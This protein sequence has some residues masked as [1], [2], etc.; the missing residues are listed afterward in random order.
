LH[1]ALAAYLF[2]L[3]EFDPKM[4]VV[5]GDSAGGGMVTSLLV[6]LRDQGLPQPAGAMLL[7]PWVDLTHSFPSICGDGKMDYIP[8][9]GFVHRPSVAWPPPILQMDES[10]VNHIGNGNAKGT[11]GPSDAPLM[12]GGQ[13]REASVEQQAKAT[14]RPKWIPKHISGHHAIP[15]VDLDGETTYIRDQLQLYTPNYQLLNP[16]VSPILNPSLGGLCPLL[17]QVG[18]G[19]LLCDEQIYF[20]HKAANPTAFPPSPEI[21]ARYDPN[22]EILHKYSPTKVQLQV[23]DDVCHVTHTLAWTK[24]AKYMYRSVAQFGAWALAR[25]QKTA[26]DIDEGYST[27][28]SDEEIEYDSADEQD[29]GSLQVPIHISTAPNASNVSRLRGP[30]TTTLE[31]VIRIGKAG[32]PLPAFEDHMIRQ[33]VDRNGNIYPLDPISLIAALRLA[34][35]EIGV[36]KESPVHR[37]RERQEKWNKKYAREKAAV[38]KRREEMEAKGM[39]P[40][41]EGETPPPTALVRRWVGEKEMKGGRLTGGDERKRRSK[42]VGLKWWT[43][44]GSKQD[45]TTVRLIFTPF[46]SYHGFGT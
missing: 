22:G 25:A 35:S 26:I 44:W 21:M 5:A 7:S 33:R 19:E 16:L 10:E 14:A 11:D 40:G 3:A 20:A 32:D 41:M 6:L 12:N 9:R 46:T 28:G 27:S 45:K 18:G 34:P 23:W 43:G 1:D 4:I 36:M 17:I 37:W 13:P 15:T 29:P 24:P 30:V 31:N 42:G 8:T 39:M 38:N 2:L